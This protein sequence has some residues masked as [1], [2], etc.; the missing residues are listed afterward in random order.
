[1]KSEAEQTG[2]GQLFPYPSHL[3]ARALLRAPLLF[4]RLGLGHLLNLMH[5]MVITTRGRKSGQPR[6]TPV[7]YR[8]HGSKI[9][10]ISGWGERP[11]WVQ[12]LL[13]DPKVTLQQGGQQ[14]AAQAQLV[15]DPGEALR[16]LNLFR[17]NT[18]VVF[19]AVIA[20]MSDQQ[21]INVKT[22]P[23][24]SDR[25]TIVR[26]NYLYGEVPPLPPLQADLKWLLPAFAVGGVL[27]TMLLFFA[28]S[29]R[30]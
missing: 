4:Y 10:V 25:F 26:F 20:R 7:E 1:L 23:A 15:D 9:Y 11:N 24:I 3:F 27:T 16:V 30:S 5:M 22:L 12:N 6:W 8:R 17:K 19:D 18:P 13:V 28:R 29:R 14:M 2:T 21:E